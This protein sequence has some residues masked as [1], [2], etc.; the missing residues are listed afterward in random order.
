MEID[1]RN[2]PG[3]RPSKLAHWVLTCPEILHFCIL[4]LFMEMLTEMSFQTNSLMTP[5]NIYFFTLNKIF[6]SVAKPR[7]K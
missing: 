1:Q 3:L 4:P 5:I 6:Q 2:N 7:A